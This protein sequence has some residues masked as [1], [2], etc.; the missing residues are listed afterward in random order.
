MDSV[1]GAQ[2]N[3]VDKG[4]FVASSLFCSCAFISIE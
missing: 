1:V 4:V 3:E 2:H